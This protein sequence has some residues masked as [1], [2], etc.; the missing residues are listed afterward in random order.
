MLR[1]ELKVTSQPR[2][3]IIVFFFFVFL[4]YK[5][6][7]PARYCTSLAAVLANT[8][9][10][11]ELVLGA[12][13]GSIWSFLGYSCFIGGGN[14]PQRGLLGEAEDAQEFARGSLGSIPGAAKRRQERG[15]CGM[16]TQSGLSAGGT[17]RS[18]CQKPV[19]LGRSLGQSEV[20]QEWSVLRQVREH[21]VLSVHCLQVGKWTRMNMHL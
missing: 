21:L 12:L 5:D 9:R 14:V 18:C 10:A 15:K 19:L 8:E 7:L 16:R 2:K 6:L 11:I 20:K 13:Q 4:N 17:S 3:L 1:W